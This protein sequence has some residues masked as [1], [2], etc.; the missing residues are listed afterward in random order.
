MADY[1]AKIAELPKPH[2]LEEQYMYKLICNLA[3]VECPEPAQNPFWRMQ[4]YWKMFAEIAEARVNAPVIPGYNTVGT[5]EIKDAC[6]VIQKLATEV[7]DL[8]L[9]DGKVTETM[10]HEDVIAKLLGTGN[11]QTE[12]L[13]DGSVT[14]EKLALEFDEEPTEG[15]SNLVTSDGI[16]RY[17]DSV[18]DFSDVNEVGF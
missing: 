17:V 12:N 14:N 5:D 9:G 18:I 3:E 15:S 13:A 1:S 2:S 16:K 8:L 4:Q 6:I 7:T 10:L 11:V